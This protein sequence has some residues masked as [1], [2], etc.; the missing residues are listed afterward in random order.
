MGLYSIFLKDWLKVFPRE[1]II[2]IR[3]E[4][5]KK[6]ILGT[7][8]QIYRHLELSMFFYFGKLLSKVEKKILPPTK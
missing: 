6:D 1:Q 8:K 5:Y 3:S 2:I 7:L 4:D